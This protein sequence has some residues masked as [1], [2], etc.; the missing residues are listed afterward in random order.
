MVNV[1]IYYRIEEKTASHE[2]CQNI[3]FYFEYTY[4]CLSDSMSTVRYEG[5]K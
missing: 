2:Y 3:V 1:L 5:M 4:M